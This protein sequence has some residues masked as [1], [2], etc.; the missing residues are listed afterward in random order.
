MIHRHMPWAEVLLVVPA[1]VLAAVGVWLMR[2][3]R[4]DLQEEAR[5]DRLSEV[6]GDPLPTTSMGRVWQS[7]QQWR[8]TLR[9]PTRL[10]L[11]VSA[12][13]L[14]YHLSAWVLPSTWM[15]F[16]VPEHRWWILVLGVLLA[17]SGSLA[18]DRWE[19]RESRR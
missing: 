7:A 16:R 4:L 15:P 17:V 8:R 5:I 3:R 19:R 6:R 2:G 13:L 18:M 11:G 9:E 10:V 1:L 14:G 12:L